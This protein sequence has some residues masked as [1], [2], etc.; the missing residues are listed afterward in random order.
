MERKGVIYFPQQ[1]LLK[2]RST[3]ARINSE[4]ACTS[5][6]CSACLELSCRAAQCCRG[7]KFKRIFVF[8][9]TH[10]TTRCTMLFGSVCSCHHQHR[11]LSSKSAS[12]PP[13]NVLASLELW[14]RTSNPH[15]DANQ[16]T[17]HMYHS[18]VWYPC[19]RSSWVKCKIILTRAPQPLSHALHLASFANLCTL[20]TV[21]CYK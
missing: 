13:F 8:F 1:M 18:S 21:L 7:I 5:Y 20:I 6:P 19:P 16:T 17:A 10:R 15:D 2:G 9:S 12:Q 14:Q 11:I 4:R 3:F